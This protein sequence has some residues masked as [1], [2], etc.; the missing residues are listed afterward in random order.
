VHA[1]CTFEGSNAALCERIVSSL[2]VP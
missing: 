1:L 2:V